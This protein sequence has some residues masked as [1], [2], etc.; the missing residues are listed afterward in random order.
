MTWA[1]IHP[2]LVNW[3]AVDTPPRLHL[4]SDT[5]GTA[6]VELAWDPQALLAPAVYPD[7]L[8]YYASSEVFNAST[9][10]DDGTAR[11]IAVPAQDIAV[12][13]GASTPWLVPAALWA[14]YV[15][16]ARK[17]LRSPATTTFSG[18]LYYRVRVT[19]PGAAQATIWPAD[20]DLGGADA[21]NA[22]HIGVLAL[23]PPGA[24]AAVPDAAAVAAAGGWSG[25]PT[26]WADA[27]EWCWANLPA[28]EASRVALDT[29]FGHHVYLAADTAT[30]GR[31]LALWLV[32]GPGVRSRLDKLLD[33]TTASGAALVTAPSAHDG[34]TVLANLLALLD[35]TPHPEL[36]GVSAKEHIVD[37]VATELLDPNGQPCRG[38]A[39]SCTPTP[40]ADLMVFARPA[41][42][43]RLQVG[44]LSCA[45][46]ATLSNGEALVVPAATFAA[47]R[48]ASS[49]G[50]AAFTVRTN[51]ELVFQAAV[52]AYGLG[53]PAA[54]P[55]ADDR[56]A[57]A[58]FQAAVAT[59]LTA[60]Q[61][62][63]ALT[64]LFATT[65][66]IHQAAWPPQP[67]DQAWLD[68]Q[69]ALFAGLVGELSNKAG[70]VILSTFWDQLPAGPSD[71]TRTLVAGAHDTASVTVTATDYAAGSPPPYAV[72]T[73]TASL[74][75]RRYVDPAHRLESIA[76]ADLAAWIFGYLTPASP[77]I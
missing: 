66:A 19:A 49:G 17:T 75:P 3:P 41:E 32:A 77:I 60:V 44:L 35:I 16:E 4:S 48:A 42:Y 13:A 1:R 64:A 69:S 2:D 33:A 15:Q 53:A 25:A 21:A 28:T 73:G 34:S 52:L 11:A 26:A 40:M 5:T 54:A 55:P 68:M 7:A 10:D 63:R 9:V 36:L 57:N 39:G 20:D 47:G 29:I 30:R 51:A 72:A 76:D 56:A 24:T 18:N 50:G 61:A 37:D 22:P 67:G 14:G 23:S 62:A 65:F 45:G 38:T 46:T 74:P 27:I 58:A 12:V 6:V 59:G 70:Q 8:R 43:A 71:V 31:L